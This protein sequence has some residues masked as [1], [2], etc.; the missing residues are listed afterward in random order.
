MNSH[1]TGGLISAVERNRRRRQERRP[2]W[3]DREPAWRSAHPGRQFD[4]YQHRRIDQSSDDD[5]RG[6]RPNGTQQRRVRLADRICIG[7][8]DDRHPA[9]HHG[10]RADTDALEGVQRC[11]QRNPSLQTGIAGRLQH[12]IDDGRATGGQG[13]RSDPDHPGVAVPILVRTAG[14]SPIA[15]RLNDRLGRPRRR[16][17]HRLSHEEHSAGD[18]G[19]SLWQGESARVQGLSNDGTLH[20]ERR[21]LGQRNQVRQ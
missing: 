12:A 1:R 13:Q 4:L 19:Q 14:T 16:P 9:G 17:R 15:N 6:D 20:T 3:G 18:R 7:R 5:H 21:Q 11:P 2:V 8:I 10:F